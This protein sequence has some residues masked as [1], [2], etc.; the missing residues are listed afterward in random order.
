MSD[1]FNNAKLS[2]WQ[3]ELRNFYMKFYLNGVWYYTLT[4]ILINSTFLAYK[5][6]YQT[7]RLNYTNEL[8]KSSQVKPSVLI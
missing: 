6:D 4:I 7:V 2:A 8:L 1:F 5:F 3:N